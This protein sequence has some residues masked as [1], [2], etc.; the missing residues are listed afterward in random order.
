LRSFYSADR[1]YLAQRAIQKEADFA[2]ATVHI[3]GDPVR[4][5]STGISYAPWP[6]GARRSGR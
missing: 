6:T 5:R 1:V 2:R 3:S 4:E